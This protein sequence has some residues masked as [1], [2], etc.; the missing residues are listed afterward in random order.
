[1]TKEHKN[2][3]ALLVIDVQQGLFQK[4]HPVYKADELLNNIICLAERAHQSGV[5]V[6]YIQ[7]CDQ[8][9]LAQ[10]SDGW[11]LHPRLQPQDKDKLV[12]KQKSNSFEGTNL[13]E[14]LRSN[15]I[16]SL[17]ITG[18]VTHGC[19]KNGCLGAL[20]LGYKVTLVRDAHSSF[21]PKAS[22]L[23]EEWNEKLR[24]ENVALE[25]ASGIIF[26]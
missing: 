9:D 3:R 11:K 25:F 24:N 18:L 2:N 1:M 6:Y 12:F 23:I 19:V 14:L 16:D 21:S 17:V 20:Q 5:P 8:R 7:H 15:G 10:G 26:A 4:S 22:E 13:D